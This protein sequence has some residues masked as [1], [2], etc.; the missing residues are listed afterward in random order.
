MVDS[1]IIHVDDEVVTQV[2]M[3]VQEDPNDNHTPSWC[4]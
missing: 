1:P 2:K 4:F 3:E